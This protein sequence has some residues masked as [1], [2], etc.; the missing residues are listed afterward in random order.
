MPT[1]VAA[2][3]CA[4][5]CTNTRTPRTKPNESTVSNVPDTSRTSDLQFYNARNRL[6]TVPGDSV[7]ISNF[8]DGRHVRWLMRVH[9]LLDDVCNRGK[10]QAACE[11]K[12]DGD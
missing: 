6:C 2:G 12:R 8:T 9:R 10:R 4:S 3:K 11:K 1:R 5:A 7:D